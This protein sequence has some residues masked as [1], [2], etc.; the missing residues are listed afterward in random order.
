MAANGNAVGV[1]SHQPAP[2]ALLPA[3]TSDMRPQHDGG[4]I[5]EGG[6][7]N[8]ANSVPPT[9]SVAVAGQLMPTPLGASGAALPGTIQAIV[10][11]ARNGWLDKTDISALVEQF[12]AADG[13]PLD[14]VQWP[15]IAAPLP[16][17]ECLLH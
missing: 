2:A 8:V 15:L 5:R 17:S 16:A 7:A 1:L 11:R 13:T 4:N 14:T 3:M 9:I 12:I 10:D 6:A